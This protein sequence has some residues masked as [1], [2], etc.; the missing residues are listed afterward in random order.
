LFSPVVAV[1]VAALLLDGESVNVV[2]IA[3]MAVV[4]IALAMLVRRQKVS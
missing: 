4:L 1:A 3:G 2:Q